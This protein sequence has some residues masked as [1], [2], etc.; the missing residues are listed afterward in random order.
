MYLHIVWISGT[1]VY[2]H[3]CVYVFGFWLARVGFQHEHG[4]LCLGFINTT[5]GYSVPLQVF[6]VKRLWICCGKFENEI[7]VNLYSL[8]WYFMTVI[9]A[10]DEFPAIIWMELIE[11]THA[12]H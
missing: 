9:S 5:D 10:S 6:T 8:L 3:A 1:K 12:I 11:I 4:K 7:Q 2:V